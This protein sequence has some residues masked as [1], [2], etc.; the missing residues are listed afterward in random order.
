[1]SGGDESW[2]SSSNESDDDEP[3]TSPSPSHVICLTSPPPPR[4]LSVSDL[5]TYQQPRRSSSAQHRPAA[6]HVTSGHVTACRWPEAEIDSVE[7]HQARRPTAS[8]SFDDSAIDNQST[9]SGGSRGRA[10]RKTRSIAVIPCSSDDVTPTLITSQTNMAA[11]WQDQGQAKR[12][13]GPTTLTG[14]AK[15]KMAVYE[16]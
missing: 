1:M 3:T 2:R 13:R 9:S 16:I 15:G 11:L 4:Q 6:D 5:F 12:S 14:E 10:G 8:S 7:Q